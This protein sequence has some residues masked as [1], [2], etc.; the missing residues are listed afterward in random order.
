MYKTTDEIFVRINKGGHIP[1]IGICGPIP[2]PIKVSTEICLKL[3]NAGIDIHQ[4]DPAT[5]QTVKLTRQN[6]FDDQKFVKGGKKVVKP[7]L[8]IVNDTAKENTPVESIVFTGTPAKAD[9]KKEE[10]QKTKE[11][12]K[13]VKQEAPTQ[14]ANVES[15]VNKLNNSDQSNKKIKK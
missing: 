10:P 6:V 13:E 4:F 3:V 8:A 14:K 7:T 5:K 2:N 9:V 15:T 1:F 11:A 12:V